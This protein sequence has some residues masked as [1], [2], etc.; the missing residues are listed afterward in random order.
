M[1]SVHLAEQLGP[2]QRPLRTV[3]L[4]KLRPD[5]TR[6]AQ[7]SSM[8]RD[9]MAFAARIHHPNIVQ[10]VD[11]G[12]DDGA[13]FIAMEHVD[14]CS[15]AELID[16]L[17]A[18]PVGAALAVAIEVASAL[19]AAHGHVDDDDRPTPVVHRDVSP[20]NI[21]ISRDG[22]VKLL[23]F[24]IARAES[25]VPVGRIDGRIAYSSPEQLTGGVIE[26]RSDLWSLGAVLYEALTG[27]PPFGRS[28]PIE[29]M[30][31][32]MAG[33]YVP[34]A[35]R[36]PEAACCAAILT[37]SLA[38]EPKR[39]WSSAEAFRAA[40]LEAA[41]ARPLATRPM[42]AALVACARAGRPVSETPISATPPAPTPPPKA[43]PVPRR[44]T[45][46]LA[47]PAVGFALGALLGIA[48]APR[49]HAAPAPGAARQVSAT[50]GPSAEAAL[51][52]RCAPTPRKK[53][54]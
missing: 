23:D 13:Y 12:V 22:R 1:G 7:A 29:L 30:A 38:V 41:D 19:S 51:A 45:R 35:E 48:D 31:A 20:E 49:T 25:S 27:A 32:A 39:R 6:D 34:I 8:F 24:G 4:K 9:E 44:R 16:R 2:D 36:R 26:R 3:A 47:V 33:N 28:N 46:W 17:G 43:M 5:L 11:V 54:R 50:E 10:S 37:R 21:M 42:L 15:L 14:G 40:C 53:H 18:L 52:S